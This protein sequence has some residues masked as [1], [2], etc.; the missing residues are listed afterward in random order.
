V[1]NIWSVH[2]DGSQSHRVTDQPGTSRQPWW[3]PDGGTLALSADRGT[4]AFAAW[5]LAADGSNARPIRTTAIAWVS[6]KGAIPIIGPRTRAQ[7]E[8]NLAAVEVSLSGDQ[9]RRLDEVSAISLG[10]PHD[11]LADP[12]TQDRIASG[13]RALLAEPPGA[14]APS[15]PREAAR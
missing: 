9:V 3:S 8:D 12:A 13:K 1:L 11:L 2:P 7:L 10:F 6:A 14:L 4:A 5:L 15:E